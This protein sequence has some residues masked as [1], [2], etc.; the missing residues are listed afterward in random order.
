MKQFSCKYVI[1]GAGLSGLTLAYMLNKL[2]ETDFVILESRDRIG[3]RILTSDAIDFGATWFHSHHQHVVR[4]LHELGVEKFNQYDKGR[5]VLV[6]NTMAPA[7]YFE[8]HTGTP[9]AYRIV[10]GSISLIEALARPFRNNIKTKARVISVSEQENKIYV[11]TET[12]TFRAR[13]VII[14]IPPRIVS[15]IAFSPQ[16]PAAVTEAMKQTHTWMS[17]AM[18]IGM[19]FKQPFWRLK[20]LSGTLIG[21]VG[22]VVELHDHT[23]FKRQYYVLMGFINEGLRD[24]PPKVRKTRILNYLQKYLGEEVLDYTLY[25]EKDW[26]QD[27]DT[28]CENIKS[29]YMSPA[30]GNPVFRDFY[31]NGKLLFSGAETSPVYGG[32]MDGAIYSGIYAT[33]K[34]IQKT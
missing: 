32:Y 8:N 9:A 13:K 21:Q 5:S 17:N 28:S 27:K 29:I 11:T 3:G 12:G 26:S 24:V 16:L 7:H 19:T 15:R 4:L 22:P 2:G 18:K 25:R 30:Y 33:K 20:K 6:Y 1:V 10:N 23:D 14:T 31:M 34:V